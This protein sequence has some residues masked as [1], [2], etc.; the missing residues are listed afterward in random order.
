MTCPYALIPLEVGLVWHEVWEA[1][2]MFRFRVQ[3]CSWQVSDPCAFLQCSPYLDKVP[4]CN[5]LPDLFG[6][7]DPLVILH[8]GV[9]SCHPPKVAWAAASQ[10]VSEPGQTVPWLALPSPHKCHGRNLFRS[11][12]V[13]SGRPGYR[14]GLF[15]MLRESLYRYSVPHM[16]SRRCTPRCHWKRGHRTDKTFAGRLQTLSKRA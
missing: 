1:R 4:I 5:S 3:F 16:E 8:C 13:V 2:R 14:L 12:A 10:V 7:T 6:C 15:G 11:E 9:M